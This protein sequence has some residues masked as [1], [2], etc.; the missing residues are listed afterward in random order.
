[1]DDFDQQIASPDQKAQAV[2][3]R[4]PAIPADSYTLLLLAGLIVL[5]ISLAYLAMIYLSYYGLELPKSSVRNETARISAPEA[6][7]I[8]PGNFQT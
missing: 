4:L 8:S 6:L 2:R 5:F 3:R 1:M 7:E